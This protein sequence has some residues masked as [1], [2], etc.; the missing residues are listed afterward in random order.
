MYVTPLLESAR[1]QSA[2]Q[3]CIYSV[4]Q[5][6]ILIV[7]LVKLCIP[8]ACIGQACEL[9][10]CPGQLL[11]C[12]GNGQCLDMSSLALLALN[13]GNLAGYTYGATPNN[14]ATW[15]AYMVQGCLCDT[16]YT[17]YDCSLLTCPTGDDPNT[18]NQYDEQQLI[19]CTDADGAGT[20]TLSFR[21][22]TT[23][24]LSGTITTADLKTALQSL[25]SVGTVS[26][27]IYTDG[28]PDK[29][30]TPYG[31][32]FLVTFLSTHGP[33]PVMVPKSGGIDSLTVTEE[34]AGTKENIPCSGRGLCDPTTGLCTCF[35]GY[36]SSDGMGNQG[37][38][39]DCGFVQA[40]YLNVGV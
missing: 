17:G 28:N 1:V 18:I 33:L 8:C 7:L 31:N 15:D 25:T 40:V 35:T 11:P 19:S 34:V 39:G 37:T 2:S 4:F 6:S 3:V 5:T 36:G 22:Q 38:L 24:I 10:N 12:N 9:L 13:N 23:V 29:L 27:D 21:L 14:P 30:C 32:Q 26:V 16:G 20:F